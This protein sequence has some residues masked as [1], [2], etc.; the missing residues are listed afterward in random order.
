MNPRA[1]TKPPMLTSINEFHPKIPS[2]RFPSAVFRGR[3][4]PSPEEAPERFVVEICGQTGTGTF[5]D[6]FQGRIP[7][8]GKA[9]RK[10]RTTKAEQTDRVSEIAF[11]LFRINNL[12]N[13]LFK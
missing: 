8:R 7:F 2:I 6:P 5:A 4:F 13:L 9:E 10:S 12:Q 11:S 1:P 3:T